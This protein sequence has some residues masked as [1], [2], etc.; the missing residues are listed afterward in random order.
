MRVAG[1][2]A[3]LED[4]ARNLIDNRRRALPGKG[5]SMYIGIGT[6]VL[7]VIIVLVILMLRRRLCC[8]N[9]PTSASAA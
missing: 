3:N 2:K 5:K 8:A 1:S 7:I 6:V 4:G 9:A